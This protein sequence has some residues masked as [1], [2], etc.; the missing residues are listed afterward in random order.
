MSKYFTLQKEKFEMVFSSYIKR[1]F[2]YLVALVVLGFV[3]TVNISIEANSA[4]FSGRV[5][6]GKGKP[7]DGIS[8]VLFPMTFENGN[9]VPLY[10][11]VHNYPSFQRTTPNEAVN[12]IDDPRARFV[13]PKSKSNSDGQFEFLGIKPGMYQLVAGKDELPTPMSVIIETDLE[14]QM[15]QIGKITLHPPPS[16]TYLD[17]VPF[18]IKSDAEIKDVEITV[19]F[20]TKIHG[21]ILF[22]DKQPLANA[23]VNITLHHCNMDGAEN[24]PLQRKFLSTDINGNFVH[25]VDEHGIYSIFATYQELVTG[26]EFFI[27]EEDGLPEALVLTLDSNAPD[28]AQQRVMI[29]PP[30]STF[31]HETTDIWVA[32][33]ENQQIY[34]R[35]ICKSWEDAQAKAILEDA[36]LVS[37][38]SEAE[39]IWLEG[40]FQNGPDWIGLTDDVKEGEWQWDSGEPVTYTNWADGDIFP[41]DLDDEEKDYVIMEFGERQWVAI[42]KGHLAWRMTQ[43]AIIEKDGLPAKTPTSDR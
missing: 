4:T 3:I 43:T 14:I 22:K 24:R 42:G 1:P 38:N 28:P 26:S 31:L 2:A 19:K 37:I 18:G 9:M 25:Y 23:P 10:H 35:I 32:N 16:V 40:I 17:M 12:E 27:F 8:I 33:P 11:A 20:R 15:I 41:N 6:N 36:H 13:T 21:K 7:L 39:Q 5:V 30:R 29:R 34:K